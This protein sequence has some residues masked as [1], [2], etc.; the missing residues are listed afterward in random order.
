M[1]IKVEQQKGNKVIIFTE[2]STIELSTVDE[3]RTIII[4]LETILEDIISQNRKQ[5]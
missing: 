2:T 4:R 3:I 1:T 5:K